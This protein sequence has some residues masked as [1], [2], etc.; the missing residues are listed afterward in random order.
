MLAEALAFAALAAPAPAIHADPI[1]YG[2]A[3]KRQMAGYSLRHYGFKQWR[4]HPKVIVLHF[5]AG[6]SYQSAWNT[7]AANAPNRGERPGTCAHFII[8]KRGRIHQL[9]SLKVRCRHAIGLNHVAIGIEMVQET[10]GHGSHWADQQILNRP[11]QVKAALRL[12]RY[13]QGRYR[14]RTRDVIGHAMAN[15]HRLF[16]DDEGWVNDHTDWLAEDVRA[17]RRRL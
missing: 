4:L 6:N 10:A 11:R 3:R 12:V 8:D 2:S 13:L 17:F 14:I 15:D 9:V 1:P 5:T 7:F 16:R